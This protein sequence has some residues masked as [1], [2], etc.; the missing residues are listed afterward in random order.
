MDK[1]YIPKR[2]MQD[3][4]VTSQRETWV[5]GQLTQNMADIE[6]KGA[7]FDLNTSELKLLQEQGI[8]LTDIAQKIY[9]YIDIEI[10][11]EIQCLGKNYEVINIKNYNSNADLRVYYV[12]RV[13]EIE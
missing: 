10:G 12:K 6:F 1:V 11:S 8:S 9:C 2:F 13:D 5:N 7:I 4:K 3:M